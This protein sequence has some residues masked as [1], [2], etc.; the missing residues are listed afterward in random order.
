MP[1][2]GRYELA[3]ASDPE[4][5]RAREGLGWAAFLAGRDRDAAELWR[6][7]VRETRNSSTLESMIAVFRATGD[8]AAEAEA[9]AALRALRGTR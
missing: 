3:L 2:L 5:V 1:P 6:P 9:R 4:D 7:L 8:A